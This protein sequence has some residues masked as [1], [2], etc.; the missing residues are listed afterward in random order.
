MKKVAVPAVVVRKKWMLL[1]V[2]TTTSAMETATPLRLRLLQQQQQSTTKTIM[3]VRAKKMAAMPRA[4]TERW[5]MPLE[6][7]IF[8]CFD[9]F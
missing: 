9:R 7:K 3:M 1:P 4:A 5:A 8:L 6:T 2:E